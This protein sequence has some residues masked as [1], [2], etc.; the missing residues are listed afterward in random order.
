MYVNRIHFY[1][2]IRRVSVEK[3]VLHLLY[4]KKY[5]VRLMNWSLVVPVSK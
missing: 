1:M 5:R 4:V 2:Y 3:A